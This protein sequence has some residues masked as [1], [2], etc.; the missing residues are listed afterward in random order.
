MTITDIHL[1]TFLDR[2]DSIRENLHLRPLTDREKEIIAGF[3]TA[4][5]GII[6]VI[7]NKP[8]KRIQRLYIRP[9]QYAEEKIKV[10][11]KDPLIVK[12]RRL[13]QYNHKLK[14]NL[15]CGNKIYQSVNVLVPV[16]VRDV[17]S[18]TVDVPIDKKITQFLTVFGKIF[19]EHRQSLNINTFLRSFYLNSLK[20][21]TYIESKL[22]TRLHIE[23]PLISSRLWDILEDQL[24]YM[25]DIDEVEQVQLLRILE[26]NNVIR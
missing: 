19:S 21:K 26:K 24:V 9:K 23:A 6:N 7:F 14:I 10:I 16:T 12:T 11:I 13:Y 4:S 2:L 15:P 25:D 3:S 8:K 17:N 1:R 22:K 18:L 20:V 5:Q